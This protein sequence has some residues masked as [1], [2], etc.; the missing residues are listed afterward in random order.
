MNGA[1]R[2]KKTPPTKRGPGRPTVRTPQTAK[3]I[4]DCVARG[5]PY[6]FACG[7]AGIGLA[8]FHE[9]RNE[10]PAF[11]QQIEEAIAL[12][13]NARLQVIEESSAAD[14][15]AAAWLLEH[16]QPQHFARNRLEVT[17]A[18]GGPL[19]GGVTLY[20]P[21]KASAAMVDVAPEAPALTERSSDASGS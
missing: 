7:A 3:T 1:M 5:M 2:T 12:G 21:Q 11:K 6:V 14:W 9:W 13:V 10:D 18:D 8:T 17:G 20:L 16:C 15:R 4:C 19:V